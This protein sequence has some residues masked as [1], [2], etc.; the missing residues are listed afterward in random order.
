MG[1]QVL[2]QVLHRNSWKLKKAR[3]I[4]D[5]DIK[6]LVGEFDV[7]LMPLSKDTLHH[8]WLLR[9]DTEV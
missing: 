3:L 2:R 9:S 7:S 8:R 4:P 5:G 1:W 6:A